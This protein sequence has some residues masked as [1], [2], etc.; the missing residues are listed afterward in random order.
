MASVPSSQG[1]GP[2]RATT[3]T[4][5]SSKSKPARSADPKPELALTDPVGA[6]GKAPFHPK[7]ARQVIQALKKLP[8]AI[9]FLRP[10]DPIL[11]GAPTYLEE[12][13]HPM[14]L[15][16]MEKKITGGSYSRMSEFA[17]DAMLI[18]ANARQFNPPATVP[19]LYADAVEATFLQEWYKALVPS[20]EYAEKRALQGLLSRLKNNAVVSGLFLQPVDPIALGIPNYFEVIPRENARDLSLIEHKLKSDQYNSVKAFTDDIGLMLHNARTFNALD[21]TVLAMV[22]TFEKQYR[23][24]LATARQSMAHALGDGGGAAKRKSTGSGG[25]SSNGGVSK[26]ARH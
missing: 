26:K 2:G 18:F 21:P 19:Y 5:A 23:K 20:L 22:D 7:R 13:A 10:V 14:D 3:P 15:G 12:I 16:T 6:A 25:A 17:A 9:F 24:E 11:D 8:E 1:P 4:S